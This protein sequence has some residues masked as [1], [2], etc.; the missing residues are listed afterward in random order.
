MFLEIT[1]MTFRVRVKP[2]I[3]LSQLRLFYGD[4]TACE[5]HSPELW[6]TV[7]H[8]PD[9]DGRANVGDTLSVD[10]LPTSVGQLQV[11]AF[12]AAAAAGVIDLWKRVESE[13]PKPWLYWKFRNADEYQRLQ[14][15][16][17]SFY[18]LRSRE[19]LRLPRSVSE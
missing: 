13:R 9:C 3:S 6:N 1:P 2:G 19:R 7:L 14:I 17:G 18:I 12:E 8:H 4:P 16:K 15:N 5:I 11:A 10:L